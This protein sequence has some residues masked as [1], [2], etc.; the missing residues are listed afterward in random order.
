MPAK[1]EPN[2][3]INYGWTGGE[4]GINLQ[5]DENWRA[6]GAL[7]QLTVLSK[8]SGVPASPNPGD[9]YIVPIGATGV[10]A[11]L[12]NKVV[13][14]IEGVWEVYTPLNGWLAYVSDEDLFHQ[15]N[16]S[17]WKGAPF[18]AA[19]NVS[20]DPTGNTLS[21]TNVQAAID[22]LEASLSAGGVADGGVQTIKLA[23]YAL[24]PGTTTG[25]T[26]GF[27]G[28][29]MSVGSTIVVTPAGTVSLSASSTNYIEVDKSGVV[30]A[31][32]IGFTNGSVPLHI[33]TTDSSAITSQQD[34]RSW[35]NVADMKPGINNQTGTSYTL[36]L[37]DD[38][39]VVRCANASAINVTV[40]AEATTDFP[41][42]AIIQVR[43]V[44]AGQ[45]TLVADTGV[46]L[47][48][49]E[50]LKT[51]KQGSTIALMKVGA[52]EWDVTGDME[53]AV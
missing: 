2:I 41:V 39:K 20:Y 50:T 16:G 1:Q 34:R 21:G 33:V 48:T 22:E 44:D 4:S 14:Y 46:T 23:D 27:K 10:W 8:T 13:R 15:F 19:A 6:I 42:G 12:D 47:I 49:P 5:L 35:I 11:G 24:D 36:V 18:L 45:V 25:L 9:R 29:R 26:F 31:N 52:D 51:R 7:L 37:S 53:G 32:I 40:P 43:Q 30:S 28:G 3:G 17:I 38:N